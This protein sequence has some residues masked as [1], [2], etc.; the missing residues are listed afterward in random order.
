MRELLDF[1]LFPVIELVVAVATIFILKMKVKVFSPGSWR[2]SWAPSLIA[3]IA[4]A[5]AAVFL[6]LNSRWV[7]VPEFFFGRGAVTWIFMVVVAP[8]AEETL[9]RGAFYGILEKRKYSN[10]VVILTTAF[11]FGSGH[12]IGLL[13]PGGPDFILFFML[14]AIFAGGVG[15][16]LGQARRDSGALLAPM[17]CHAVC[18]GVFLITMVCLG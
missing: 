3:G 14:Q 6:Y 5:G 12:L 13:L 11:I 15:V 9:F 17:I 16:L 18:N 10:R 7:A 2:A 1:S 8:I 4:A